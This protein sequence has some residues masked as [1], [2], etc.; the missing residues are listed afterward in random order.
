M[1]FEIGKNPDF[2]VP[3]YFNLFFQLYKILLYLSW[4]RY[5]IGMKFHEAVQD[6]R[7]KHKMDL[8][9]LVLIYFSELS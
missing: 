9:F 3:L 5:N 7:M 2:S 4:E 6:C 1:L 8:I